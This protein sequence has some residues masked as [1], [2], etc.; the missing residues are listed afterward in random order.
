[1]T[2]LLE[3]YRVV[4]YQDQT[5]ENPFLEWDFEP[6]ILLSNNKNWG[7]GN[8]RKYIANLITPEILESKRDEFVELCSLSEEE[9]YE[10]EIRTFIIS[11]ADIWELS[12]IL[13]LVNHNHRL[14]TNLSDKNDFLIVLDD[15]FYNRTGCDKE[16]ENEILEGAEKLLTQ[17]INGDV[18][19][20]SLERKEVYTNKI[21]KSIEVWESIDNVSGFYGEDIDGFV[22]HIYIE[23]AS[24]EQIVELVKEGFNNIKY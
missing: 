20:F 7:N 4:I 1:M 15:D 12:D 22:E 6:T 18:Y 9:E 24:K 11:F 13:Y 5:P 2:T 17:Y 14:I 19:S 10:Q 21:G 8:I 3:N 16:N 23:G